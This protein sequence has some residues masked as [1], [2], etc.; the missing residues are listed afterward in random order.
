MTK[1]ELNKLNKIIND[2]VEHKD[3]YEFINSQWI[4]DCIANQ[5]WVALNPTMNTL[6]A[7][8]NTVEQLEQLS[9][10]ILTN[11]RTDNNRSCRF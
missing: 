1:E 7:L 5:D 6:C 2:V 8:Q 3:Y 4:E 9:V 11:E 10:G